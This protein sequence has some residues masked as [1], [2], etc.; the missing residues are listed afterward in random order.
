MNNS[1]LTNES[2]SKKWRVIYTRSNWEKKADELLKRSG[3]NS[4]CPVVK[5]Q[6]QWADRKKVV[7][8][9]LFSSYLFVQ[10]DGIEEE[11]I[12]RIDGVIGYV[13]DFGRV[14][15]VSPA[16]I[17]LIRNSVSL[18]EDIECVNMKGLHKGD[19]VCLNDGILFNLKG[20]VVEVRGKQVVFIMKGLDCGLIAKVKVTPKS[21]SLTENL[22]N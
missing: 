1:S 3:F 17:L 19:S 8:V 10:V 15:E 13:R 2:A 6:K 4:F 7:E 12:L 5:T 20:E 18:Y 11:R 9:P 21:L 14:A 22:S 16:E